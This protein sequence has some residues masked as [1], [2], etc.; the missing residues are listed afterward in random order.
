LA[1][2]SA[3]RASPYGPL[4]PNVTS[5][6]KPEVHNIAQCR[7]RRTQPWPQGICT[8]NFVKIGPA[9]PEICSQT[10]RHTD[11]LTDCNTPLPYGGG[12]I[13]LSIFSRKDREKLNLYLLVEVVRVPY[14]YMGV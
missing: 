2:S 11:K 10:D 13:I 5:S 3:F 9:V 7:Q 4:P 1:K 12:V 14:R 6:I 8:Q